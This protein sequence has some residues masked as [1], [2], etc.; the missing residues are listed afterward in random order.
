IHLIVQEKSQSLSGDA[1]TEAVVQCSGNRNRFAF[2]IDNRI[3]GGVAGFAAKV[4]P[5][6]LL[7]LTENLRSFQGGT[8]RRVLRVYSLT[9]LRRIFLVN[10]LR[11]RNA[12]KIRISQ[13]LSPIEERTP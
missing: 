4:C 6:D 10:Q 2:R 12:R 7:E 13:E 5:C 3:M 1:R 11:D 8:W 9:P